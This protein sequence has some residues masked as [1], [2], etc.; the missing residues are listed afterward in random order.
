M[1]KKKQEL[2]AQLEAKSKEAEA[3]FD[4]EAPTEDEIK[5]ARSLTDEVVA[6]KA[7]IEELQK[8]EERREELKSIGVWRQQPANKLAQPAPSAKVTGFK[9][10]GNAE[11]VDEGENSVL[12]QDGEGLLSEAQIETITDPN[13]AK[14]VKSYIRNKGEMGRMSRDEVKAINEGI[15][16]DG[17]FLAPAEMLAK[18]IERKP[19][20]TRIA[21]NVTNLTTSRDAIVLPKS[22]YAADDIYTSGIRV[23]W[24][25]EPGNPPPA[26][27][28]AFGQFRVP[29]YTA[30]LELNLTND[31]IE[32]S[33]F[34]I[35]SY[36]ASKFSETIDILKDDMIINGNGI[37]QPT[38]ILPYVGNAKGITSMN[39]GNANLITADS[40]VSMSY[41]IPE[42]YMDNSR[43]IFNRTN[44]EKAIALLK[45]SQNRYL[46]SAGTVDA[47]VATSRPNALL[48]FSLIRSGL[49]P[50]VAAGDYPLLYGDLTAYYQI[51]RMGFTL[52]ILKE[53]EA[54]SNQVVMLGRLRFGGDIAE[55]WRLRAL[56]ISA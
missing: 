52:Q 26:T 44:T 25:G 43:W 56:K 2:L 27:G 39:S 17:G 18:L 46:F 34:P 38:G 49:M 15:D 31:M 9:A 22:N 1:D 8:D 32:D 41:D 37:S 51:M 6:I 20:P 10:T 28:P 42:Q 5:T 55:P 7:Q 13:Y 54:R 12:Y 30:M 19:T 35:Q 36:A 4:K 29:I 53:V 50:N 45:D 16:V 48:G 33:A 24:T 14:A 21:G 23:T 3:L 47:S 11:I 40:L